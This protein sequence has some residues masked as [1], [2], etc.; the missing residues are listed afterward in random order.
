MNV[1]FIASER[2][3]TV[4]I[5]KS[6][7]IRRRLESVRT[8]CPDNGVYLL[9]FIHCRNYENGSWLE[10]HLHRVFNK[11]HSHREWFFLTPLVRTAIQKTIFTITDEQIE[12]RIRKDAEDFHNR[13]IQ[14]ILSKQIVMSENREDI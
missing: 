14:N 3:G 2:C 7:N 11:Y 10:H 1:Y 5:G 4:K 12:D 9:G 8:D 6:S 13:R